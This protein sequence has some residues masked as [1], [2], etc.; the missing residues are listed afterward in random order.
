MPRRAAVTALALLGAVSAWALHRYGAPSPL[1][2]AVVL[3]F[4][5]AAADGAQVRFAP[6]LHVTAIDV[7][8]Q[9]GALF[10]GPASPLVSAAGGTLMSYGRE[11]HQRNEYAKVALA[12]NLSANVV[13][14]TL[15][16]ALVYGLGL[17]PHD[18]PDDHAA[19]LA[20]AVLLPIVAAA[21]S[22]IVFTV[23]IALRTGRAGWDVLLEVVRDIWQTL[24]VQVG[25]IFAIAV[26]Y[27]GSAV[28]GLVVASILAGA[29]AYMAQL[30]VRSR[31][32]AALATDR[33]EQM[34]A[35][36]W[37]VL[38]SLV[39]T[40]DLRSPSAARHSAAV[41]GFSRDIAAQLGHTNAEQDLAHISGLLHDIGK[42]AL[43]DLVLNAAEPLGHRTG[44]WDSIEAHPTIGAELLADL[45]EY[46]PVAEIVSQHHERVDGTGYPNGLAGDEIHP[47]ARIVACAEVYDTI[48]APDTYREQLSGI[49]AVRELR[50][51]AGGQLDP[52]VV[53]ALIAVL[54]GRDL[55]YRHRA[56]ADYA[57]ELDVQRRAQ[58]RRTS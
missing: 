29:F 2:P 21:L 38:S 19:F 41:A 15:A 1:W 51:V 47:I 35:M 23:L 39:R 34:T 24:V 33:A 56:A 58:G 27:R 25:F 22:V 50:R 4:I 16:A 26:I 5:A 32:Q 42:F 7:V 37:G 9:A 8:A 10:G 30:V 36:S 12:I 48:S 6:F 49:E 3:A 17:S 53:E 20:G 28:T 40:L 54:A 44:E 18:N 43:S 46:G 14:A 11:R 13:P 55:E 52:D 57:A 45:T 31:Q